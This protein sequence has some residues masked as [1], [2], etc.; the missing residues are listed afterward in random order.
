MSYQ[1]I[2]NRFRMTRPEI[3]AA[4]LEDRDSELLDAVITGAA[5]VAVSDGRVEPAER[6]QLLDFLRRNGLLSTITRA[7]ALDDFE[8]RTRGS[9]NRLAGPRRRS[10]RRCKRSTL[11]CLQREARRIGRTYGPICGGSWARRTCGLASAAVRGSRGRDAVKAPSGG[12]H[13]DGPAA[14]DAKT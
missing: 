10:M 5:L 12:T 9:S 4:Y 8:R 2:R 14:A 1:K 6:C 13:G 11:G 3:I 7:D